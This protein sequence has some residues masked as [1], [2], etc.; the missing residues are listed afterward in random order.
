MQER[1][2]TNCSH[3]LSASVNAEELRICSIWQTDPCDPLEQK[4]L[5]ALPVGQLCDFA[6]CCDFWSMVKYFSY[7]EFQLGL[8]S[9]ASQIRGS[10]RNRRKHQNLN[11]IQ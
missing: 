11:Y 8:R 5:G 10:W 4:S 9:Q 7:L 2:D 3:G 1:V 6:H